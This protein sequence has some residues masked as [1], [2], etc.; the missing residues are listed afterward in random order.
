[1]KEVNDPELL[2]HLEGESKSSFVPVTDESI[3]NQ[4]NG[5][6]SN[7]NQSLINR[8]AN[9]P[10]TNTVLGAGDAL[11]NQVS[12]AANLLPGVNI[13]QEKSGEGTAYNVGNIAGEIAP[14]ALMPAAKLGQAGKLIEKVPKVGHYLSDM[15]GRMFPQ[16]AYGAA[17]SQNPEEGAKQSAI[18]Q[19]I[20]ELPIA[21]AKGIGAAAEFLNP[22]KFASNK[23]KDIKNEYQ[24][25]V[26]AQ[27]EAYRP[28]TEKYGDFNLTINPKG[29]LGFDKETTKYFTPDIKKSY[30]TFLNEPTFNNAHKLQSQMFK[31][32]S[33]MRNNPN[34]INTYQTIQNARDVVKNKMLSNLKNDQ[35]SLANYLR[36]SEIT[37]T[38]VSPFT[39]TPMM[40]NIVEGK[41]EKI[42][43]KKLS[44][45]LEKAIIKG[46]KDVMDNHYL[47]QAL[48]DINKK[49]TRGEAAQSIVPELTRKLVPDVMGFSQNP[50]IGNKLNSISPYY[51]K[52][53]NSIIA[54][55]LQGT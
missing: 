31:D 25:A 13:N 33:R 32:S 12:N 29:Y 50:Y 17:T 19:G 21:G 10:V 53:K 38:Q 18:M 1:M 41:V 23:I 20:G 16:V 2:A 14:F 48:N 44:G 49:T 42:K 28:V 47:S 43:P 51:E 34:K 30:E 37:R 46:D 27:K 4:L 40:R 9:N 6:Q 52:L 24:S 15:L 8:L 7:T 55:Q 35:E 45:Y 3:L 26:Q 36:G 5:N 11:R 54:S 22:V 39:S